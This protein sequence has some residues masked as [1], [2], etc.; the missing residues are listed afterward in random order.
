MTMERMKKILKKIVAKG[1]GVYWKI[2]YCSYSYIKFGP[3]VEN[4]VFDLP[5][6]DIFILF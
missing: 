1:G 5:W 2:F 4:Y 6:H 3:R